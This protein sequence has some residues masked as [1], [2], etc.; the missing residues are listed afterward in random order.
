MKF[1]DIE[2]RKNLGLDYKTN[3]NNKEICCDWKHL[4][5]GHLII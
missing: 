1:S 4:K 3:P 5:N 2:I